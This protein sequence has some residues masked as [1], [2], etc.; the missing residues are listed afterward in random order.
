LENKRPSLSSVYTDVVP[1][2]HRAAV[3]T[4]GQALKRWWDVLQHRGPSYGYYPKPSKSWLIAKEE[5]YN[6]KAKEM[7]TDIQ[8]TTKGETSRKWSEKI[9]GLAAIALHEPQLAYCTVPSLLAHRV[10]GHSS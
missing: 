9:E 4:T 5:H 2:T 6:E 7:F 1:V 8:I 10:G 3:F